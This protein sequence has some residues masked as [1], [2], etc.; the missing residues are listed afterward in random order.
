M[1]LYYDDQ[2]PVKCSCGKVWSLVEWKGLYEIG[3]Q[4][5]GA[6]PDDPNIPE[7]HVLEMRNCTCGST[8]AVAKKFP[9]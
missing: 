5:V 3:E 1:F 4:R 8:L 9:Q 7:A 6:D 2:F